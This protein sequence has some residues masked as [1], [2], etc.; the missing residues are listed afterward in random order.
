MRADF[1][2]AQSHSL[3]GDTH[4]LCK[5]WTKQVRQASHLFLF[6]KEKTLNQS[7]TFLRHANIILPQLSIY[8]Q[9]KKH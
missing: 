1:W 7:R 8:K 9:R 2:A 5:F 3:F 4:R 6:V